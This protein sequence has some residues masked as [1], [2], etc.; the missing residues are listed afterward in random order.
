[1]YLHV[2]AA[3]GYYDLATPPFAMEHTRNHLN[4]PE[5]IEENF[6]TG[7]YEG[8]HMMYAHEPSLAKLREDLVK[9]YEEALEPLEG[10]NDDE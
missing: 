3:C 7:Y 5:E 8:G 2:F 4:L 9:F 6:E 1:P 10:T